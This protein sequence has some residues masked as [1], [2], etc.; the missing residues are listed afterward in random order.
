MSR[1]RVSSQAEWRTVCRRDQGRGAHMGRSGLAP[2]NWSPCKSE[3][4]THVEE[5]QGDGA[6]T[7][8]MPSTAQPRLDPQSWTRQEGPSP[9][10]PV[11]PD[12]GLWPPERTAETPPVLSPSVGSVTAAVK[13]KTSTAPCRPPGPPQ[14][15]SSGPSRTTETQMLA[16]ALGW[17]H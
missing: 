11:T 2:S 5:P 8:G 7:R 14:T 10:S 9:H 17:A 1:T 3:T 13:H 16:R 15:S 6:E 12:F 4:Q